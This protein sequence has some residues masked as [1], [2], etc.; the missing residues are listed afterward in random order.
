MSNSQIERNFFPQA[1]LPEN[2]LRTVRG[3]VIAVMGV[4]AL[5]SCTAPSSEIP[6]PAATA[7]DLTPAEQ[8]KNTILTAPEMAATNSEAIKTAIDLID[9]ATK[10]M[11]AIKYASSLTTDQYGYLSLGNEETYTKDFGD[12]LESVVEY[13]GG[14]VQVDEADNLMTVSG[15]SSMICRN[16]GGFLSSCGLESGGGTWEFQFSIEESTKPPESLEQIKTALVDAT[17]TT[18]L[19]GDLF[20][21]SDGGIDALGDIKTSEVRLTTVDSG[22]AEIETVRNDFPDHQDLEGANLLYEITSTIGKTY[23]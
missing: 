16:E 9:V 23:K 8:D 10:Q 12:G 3:G 7:M 5:T 21:F 14:G 4:A 22:G 20:L 18:A 19:V 6:K 15:G 2:L 11:S 17:L 13:T 1:L